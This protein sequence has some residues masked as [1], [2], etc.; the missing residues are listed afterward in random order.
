MAK[1]E[2]L[3]PANLSW[4]PSDV[5][6]SLEGLYEFMKAKAEAAIQWYLHA[7]R[8]KKILAIVLRVM[9]IALGSVAAIIPILSQMITRQNGEQIIAPAWA[10]VALVLA[11][12]LIALD[13]FLGCSSSWMR[14]ISTELRLHKRLDEFQLDWQGER[15]KW[16]DTSADDKQVETMFEIAKAFIADVDKLLIDET[17]AWIAEFQ[18]SLKQIDE[19]AKMKE[20][21]KK[22]S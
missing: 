17:N 9:S 10:S 22:K 5:P 8:L 1:R 21:T 18:S 2:D 4:N 20:D 14:F 16:K 15:S 13:R 6:G 7:K 3:K 19:F 12:V 11:G